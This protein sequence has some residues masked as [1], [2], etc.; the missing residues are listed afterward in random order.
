[1]VE[2]IEAMDILLTNHKDLLTPI[3]NKVC[4]LLPA[5]PGIFVGSGMCYKLFDRQ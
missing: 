4:S 2:I 1:M 3:I 5:A